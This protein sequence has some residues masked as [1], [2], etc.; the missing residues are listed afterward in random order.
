MAW[1]NKTRMVSKSQSGTT[2]YTLNNRRN[3]LFIVAVDALTVAVGGGD[4]F[5]IPAG[6][7]WAPHITPTSEVIITGACVVTSDAV[8]P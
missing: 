5:S 4:A 7:H 1:F 3:Y 8:H 6:G 2:T